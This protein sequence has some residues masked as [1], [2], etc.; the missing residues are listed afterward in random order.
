[1]SFGN[2]EMNDQDFSRRKYLVDY[3][4]GKF[5]IDKRY[6]NKTILPPIR[7]DDGIPEA[8]EGDYL[9]L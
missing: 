6:L 4:S 3:I 5:N 2:M 7:D 8:T 9:F 1:M